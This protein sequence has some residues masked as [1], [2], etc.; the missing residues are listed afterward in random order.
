MLKLII[1]KEL[2]VYS[3]LYDT[4]KNPKLMANIFIELF[5]NVGM[6]IAEIS[7]FFTKNYVILLQLYDSKNISFVY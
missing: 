3:E 7:S 2:R 5:I 4:N 6:K 1:I